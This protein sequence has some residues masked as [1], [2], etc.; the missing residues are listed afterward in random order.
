MK[1]KRKFQMG[2]TKI[3]QSNHSLLKI[4]VQVTQSCAQIETMPIERLAVY[5]T[6]LLYAIDCNHTLSYTRNNTINCKITQ[7]T[8][9]Q[10]LFFRTD[11]NKSHHRFLQLGQSFQRLDLCNLQAQESPPVGQLGLHHFKKLQSMS[12]STMP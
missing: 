8:V 9:M 1:G 7:N 10:F 6:I 5:D 2:M 3:L 4:S 11:I 12:P